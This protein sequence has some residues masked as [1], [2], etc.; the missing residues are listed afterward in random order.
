MFSKITCLRI[1][2][3]VIFTVN[4]LRTMTAKTRTTLKL[5]VFTLSRYLTRESFSTLRYYLSCGPTPITLLERPLRLT[6]SRW[7]VAAI[8]NSALTSRLLDKAR[9][10][11]EVS[12]LL[13]A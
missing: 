3:A 4:L 13:E 5:L 1:G 9:L 2:L 12:I 10:E 7:L 11:R 8:P 6:T